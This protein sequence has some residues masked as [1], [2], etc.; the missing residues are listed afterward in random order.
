MSDRNS[1]GTAE[2][3]DFTDDLQR[4]H[5]V[6]TRDKAADG[7]FFYAVTTTGIYCR[8]SCFSR[9]PKRENVRFYN[10]AAEA[11]ADGYRACRKCLGTDI[12]ETRRLSAVETACALLDA[13]DETAPTLEALANATGL[14]RY[15]L[16]RI[17]KTATG[18]TPRQYW[19]ARRLDRLRGNL[20]SGEAISSALYGAGYGSSSRLYEKAHGQLGMTPATYGKGGR[21]AVIAFTLAPSPLGHILI[22]ATESGICFL[23]L[24]EDTGK[25]ETELRTEFPK[26]EIVRDED[27]LGKITETVIAHLEGRHPNIKLPLDIQATAFQRQV[28]EA[29]MD[30]PYGETRTYGALAEAIGKPGASRAVGRACG[31]NRVALVIPCHRAVGAGGSLTGYRWGVPRKRQLLAEE[32]QRCDLLSL[33]EDG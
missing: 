16:Q 9:R 28:W 10:S 20:K 1:F 25:L 11:E 22:A 24:G 23:A 27:T 6:E 19:D 2:S 13:A 33:A 32:C 4:W 29:L 5:A 18:V 12:A 14:S 7:A 30:V 31:S 21:G 26:A 3:K 15:H 17:F 8:P